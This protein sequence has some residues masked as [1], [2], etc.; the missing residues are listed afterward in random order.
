MRKLLLASAAILGGTTGAWAQA[1][2]PQAFQSQGMMAMPW[3]G[4]PAANNNNNIWGKAIKGTVAV[5]TPA[6]S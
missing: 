4:G 3:M 2:A 5:P 6:P 1:E